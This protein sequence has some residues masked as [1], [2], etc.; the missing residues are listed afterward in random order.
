MLTILDIVE[1]D[2]VEV[3][4]IFIGLSQFIVPADTDKP[5]SLNTGRDSPVS[6]DSSTT[7]LPATT[8]P[9]TGIVSPGKTNSESPT[10]IS[11]VGTS[12]HIASELTTSL[13]E[14][15]PE[16]AITSLD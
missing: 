8:F 14:S 4:S 11:S 16:G 5:L 6:I 2:P 3:A 7:L 12:I 9:S 13:E 1:L 10:R 15:L